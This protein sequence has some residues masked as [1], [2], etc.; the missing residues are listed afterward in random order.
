MFL[1]ADWVVK[2]V[3]LLLLAAS[4]V[5]WGVCLVKYLEF[6][7]TIRAMKADETRLDSASSLESVG[8]LGSATSVAIMDV[9][10]QEL[11]GCAD[12]LSERSSDAMT[13]RLSIRLSTV[14][15]DAI[16]SMRTGFSLLASI[17][18]TA[19]FIGLFGTVWGIMNSFIGISQ[20]QTTNLAVVA[21]GIAEAL[22]A[23]AMGLVAAIPAVLLYNFF[24]RQMAAVR[25]RLHNMTARVACLVSREVEL[26]QAGRR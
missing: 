17:G 20:A 24:A 26:A 21:P 5:T 23:T 8:T 25:R 18:A 6:N 10:R 14:E 16:Q 9:A 15:G 4:V 22:L 7:R 12:I 1:G 13:D 11:S 2:S 19:P 3:M